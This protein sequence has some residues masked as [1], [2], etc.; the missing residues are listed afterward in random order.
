MRVY[1]AYVFPLISENIDDITTGPNSD[2]GDLAGNTENDGDFSNFWD[3]EDETDEEK[4]F[5]FRSGLRKWAV[6]YQIPQVALRDLMS[7]INTRFTDN[8]LPR[9]PRTLLETPKVVQIANIGD[10]GAQYWH[11]GLKNCLRRVFQNIDGP[12]TITVNINMDGLPM[13]N[14]SKVEFWP[15][16]FNITEM[17]HLPAMPIGI[18]CGST[19]CTDLQTFLTP[20]ADEMKDAMDNGIY[21]NSHKITVRLRSIVC[22]SPARAY[23]KGIYLI[24]V[25]VLYCSRNLF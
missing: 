4:N 5:K 2:T 14:S 7:L 1:I 19:K 16:L 6:K 20:F 12:R 10:D 21:I 11:H 9:D 18:Y 17:P 13:F 25:Y 3:E 15:I 22:D 8:I 24:G 23:V